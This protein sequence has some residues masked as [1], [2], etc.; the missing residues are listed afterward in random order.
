IVGFEVGKAR[1]SGGRRR[2]PAARHEG[3]G[4]TDNDSVAAV[5]IRARYHRQR[6]QKVPR[7]G[8]FCSYGRK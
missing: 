7:R 2:P 5:P 3:H 1:L 8:V 6:G 4:N